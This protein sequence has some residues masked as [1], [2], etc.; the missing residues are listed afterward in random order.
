MSILLANPNFS[1]AQVPIKTPIAPKPRP[2]I[3]AKTSDAKLVAAVAKIQ[4]LISKLKKDLDQAKASKKK[5]N[6]AVKHFNTEYTK[7]RDL[8]Q[9]KGIADGAK[10]I[11]FQFSTIDLK[12]ILDLP[13]YRKVKTTLENIVDDKIVRRS[14]GKMFETDGQLKREAKAALRTLDGLE[15]YAKEVKAKEKKPQGI[16][17]PNA[18]L[19]I[20]ELNRT[21]QALGN[22]EK[23]IR[24]CPATVAKLTIKISEVET[25]IK[26]MEASKEKK[27]MIQSLKSELTA[28]KACITQIEG[29]FTEYSSIKADSVSYTSKKIKKSIKD[30]N[31]AKTKAAK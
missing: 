10:W 7:L 12:K 30:L 18:I 15:L 2:K 16:K 14:D 24:T 13:H 9:N 31:M 21:L 6:S 3:A 11:R 27:A 8:F 23:E 25:K 29:V 5:M 20:A 17:D 22:L 4:A 19:N 1:Q 28:L 26:K